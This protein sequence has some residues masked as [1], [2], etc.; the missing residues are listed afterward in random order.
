[1][2]E[3]MEEEIR[4][5]VREAAGEPRSEVRERA[6]EAMGTARPSGSWLR[7]LPA[8]VGAGLVMAALG[9]LPYSASAPGGAMGNALAAQQAM[10]AE[11]LGEV[12]GEGAG[13][14]VTRESLPEGLRAYAERAPQFVRERYPDDPEML[15][16]AGLLTRNVNES[17]ALLKSAV[18]KSD[19]AAAW[20]A[21]AG[22]VMEMGP[23]YYRL[24]T[25]A[26]DPEDPEAVT[27]AEREIGES[28]VPQRLTPKEAE[29][30][31][32]VVK[33]WRKV[34]PDNAV[35]LAFEMYYLYGLHRD[36]EALA[37]WEEAASL[38][39][40]NPHAQESIW[41]TA[42]L[43]ERMGMSPWD[44]ISNSY[45]SAR[46]IGMLRH[47]ARIGV[48]EGRLARLE[49]RSQD[50]IRLWMATIDFGRHM[51]Q[52]ADTLTECLVGMA[53][54]GIGGSPVCVWQSDRITGIPDGP[55]LGGRL[56]HGAKHDFFVAQMG[57]PAANAARDSMVRAKARSMMV[58]K[59]IGS[60]PG[61]PEG[62]LRSMTLRA[63]SIWYG[64]LLVA[65]LLVFGGVSLRAR[66]RADEATSLSWPWRTLLALLALAPVS[67][68][69]AVMWSALHESTMQPGLQVLLSAGMA[70]TLL[71]MLLLPL[72]AAFQS[73]T[74]GAR[75]VTAWRGNLRRVLPVGIVV[76]AAL[77]LALGITGRRAGA[78]WARTWLSET[79][80]DRVVR[81]IGPEW[82]DPTI[83]PDAWRNEPPPDPRTR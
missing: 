83:P 31:L 72:L 76:L 11:A 43:L 19:S 80:M 14:T 36:Q 79:E 81:Q 71:S 50:A 58:R 17:L 13:R 78:E 38:P 15:M 20:A 33:Q 45:G 8:A 29:P 25:W 52:S 7:R 64:V 61:L 30:V 55:L 47:C 37:R 35:P 51:Q 22:A 2:S 6:L 77:S 53:I 1:M 34:E 12:P 63:I 59:Y 66:K 48:Y 26:V 60:L 9:L 16:A 75:L 27:E 42:G 57:E 68:A 69:F 23:A 24:A 32:N 67:V 54:E 28:D 49:G 56:F 65:C 82:H 44:A 21:Y 74:A 46:L 5:A 70:L 3:R 62:Q 41:Y 73:R 39:E 40:V 4:E 18:D 10:A